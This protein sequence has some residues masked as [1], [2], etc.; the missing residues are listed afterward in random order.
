[1]RRATT[2]ALMRAVSTFGEGNLG[3][4][5]DCACAA[6]LLSQRRFAVAGVAAGPFRTAGSAPL[7]RIFPQSAQEALRSFACRS[8][9]DRPPPKTL[10][11]EYD[12][13]E[14]DAFIAIADAIEAAYPVV[15]EGNPDGDGRLGS[16]EVLTEDGVQIYSKLESKKLPS[17]DDVIA[18]IAE[19]V[20]MAKSGPVSDVCG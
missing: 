6:R 15:V 7:Q 1:M 11:I 10:V 19:R 8:G 17:E 9:L 16:F 20:K 3:V 18:S 13:A 2:N 12:P 4:V 5:A 14:V